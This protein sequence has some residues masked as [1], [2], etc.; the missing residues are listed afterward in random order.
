ML[1][2]VDITQPPLAIFSRLIAATLFVLFL[3]CHLPQFHIPRSISDDYLHAA[4]ATC[5]TPTSD[6]LRICDLNLLLH[7]GD[8]APGQ[9]RDRYLRTIPS[10]LLKYIAGHLPYLF[11]RSCHRTRSFIADELATIKE[12]RQL[13]SLPHSLS[14]RAFFGILSRRILLSPRP[15]S[16][17][18]P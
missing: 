8:K 18:T 12:T 7:I 13:C 4:A 2:A 10:K 1:S 5:F 15:T 3:A 11:D 6:Y 14:S 16:L 17:P 9:W